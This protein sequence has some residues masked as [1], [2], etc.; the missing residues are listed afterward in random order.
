M[1]MA[2]AAEAMRQGEFQG[3]SIQRI[4]QWFNNNRAYY[5]PS[6]RR[7]GDATS[8]ARFVR[9]VR[10]FSSRLS[11][12]VFAREHTQERLNQ[13]L[14][15]GEYLTEQLD[16]M[17]ILYQQTLRRIEEENELATEHRDQAR[18]W[19]DRTLQAE[20][21]LS[22]LE[23]LL[24]AVLAHADQPSEWTPL[25]SEDDRPIQCGFLRAMF[26]LVRMRPSA[27]RFNEDFILHRYSGLRCFATNIATAG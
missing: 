17:N 11:E 2:D 5:D 24:D 3:W 21:Q 27:R 13:A 20:G 25:F 22:R 4:R 7:G 9:G 26:D 19:R 10:S 8:P 14:R 23:P 16:A 18:M 12:L 15:R 1:V 6:F